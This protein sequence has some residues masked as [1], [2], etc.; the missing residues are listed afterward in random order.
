MHP[1]IQDALEITE[2]AAE[3]PQKYFRTVF[4]ISHK[5]DKSPV[6]IADQETEQFIRKA[7]QT[8]FP[9]HDIF[10]E[11]F[12]RQLTDSEYEWI[13]DP[14]DGT[15]SFVTGMPLYGMLLALLRNGEPELGV[16]RMPELD[17]VYCGDNSSSLRNSTEPLNCSGVTSLEEA[18]IYINEGEKIARQYP[19]LFSKLSQ[20]GRIVRLGYDCYPHMLLASG[21]V[22]LV[23]DFDL[24]PYDYFAL[25]P[26]IKGA[27]GYISD[28]QGNALEM[29]SNGQGVSAATIQLQQ[30]ILAILN[31]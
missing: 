30:Q 7:L 20:L 4:D 31:N 12:G 29:A 27:G 26:V 6:T 1:F 28:W 15:R 14:I 16:V 19:A 10:G 13:I 21:K 18:G 2:Q 25:I 9:E 23:I 22:D 3:I 5:L 17:E 8:R 11:E 24:K